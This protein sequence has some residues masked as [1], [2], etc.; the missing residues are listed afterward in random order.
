MALLSLI[1][2]LAITMALL[3]LVSLLAIAMHCR[4]LFID[5]ID[6]SFHHHSTFTVTRFPIESFSCRVDLYF[7][8]SL[9]SRFSGTLGSHNFCTIPGRLRT[10]QLPLCLSSSESVRELL[11]DHRILARFELKQTRAALGLHDMIC[12]RSSI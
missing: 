3:S 11:F 7:F 1:L 12:F 5:L 4:W 9:R 8:P 6:H 10:L 2:L